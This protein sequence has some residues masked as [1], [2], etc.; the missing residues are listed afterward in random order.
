MARDLAISAR[1]RLAAIDAAEQLEDLR[2]PPGNRLEAPRGGRTG[3][4]SI[5]INGQWRIVFEWREDGAHDVT[6]MDYH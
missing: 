5:R 6:I 4:H 2:I 3:S 1:R